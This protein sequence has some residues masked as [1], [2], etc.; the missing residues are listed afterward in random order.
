MLV[1]EKNKVFMWVSPNFKKK[2]KQ[3][4]AFNDKSII[5]Y[6]ND[7]ACMEDPIEQVIKKKKRGG[8]G[9]VFPFRF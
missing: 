1:L 6:T 8:G 2:L 5:D 7:L 4:A 3:E 9:D